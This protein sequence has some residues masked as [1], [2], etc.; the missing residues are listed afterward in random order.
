[1]P[2][3]VWKAIY[4]HY[5]PVGVEAEAP[6]SRAQLGDAAVTWASVSLADKL[7]SVVGMFQAGER[8]TGSRDPLG[9]RRLAQG[10]VKILVDLPELTGLELR[11]PLGRLLAQAAV[12]FGGVGESGAPLHAFMTDRLTYLLEQRGFDVR[13]IRAVMHGGL[14]AISPLEARRKL[15]ALSRMAGS[16]ALLGVA[17]LLKRVKNISKGVAVPDSPGRNRSLLT[18]PA[19]Q[20]L[21]SALDGSAAGIRTASAR[22][23]YG[24]A[25][26]GIA[27]LQP[28]VAK[29]FDDVLVMAEDE[30]VRAA[31]L[32][33]VASLRGLILEIADLSE[34]VTD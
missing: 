14:E 5:M 21:A 33:L 32:G 26:N 15:E 17:M 24:D 4:Y 20:A 22:G 6:P 16:E 25:F 9:L 30:R 34:I 29:F 2:E 7:D 3:D 1:L 19:E 23:D 27:A 10:A 8:P 28:V 11:L 13:S 18:E 12:P 31:R